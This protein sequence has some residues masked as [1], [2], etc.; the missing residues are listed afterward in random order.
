MGQ[1]APHIKNYMGENLAN[2]KQ[3]ENI[4]IQKVIYFF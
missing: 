4:N 1:I 3:T 2:N